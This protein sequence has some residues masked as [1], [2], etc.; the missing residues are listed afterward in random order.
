VD[1]DGL[2]ILLDERIVAYLDTIPQLKVDF[3][4]SRFGSGFLVE[5]GSTC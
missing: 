1:S 5:G 4:E 2:K 3:S